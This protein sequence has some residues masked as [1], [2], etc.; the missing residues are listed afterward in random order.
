[1]CQRITHIYSCGHTSPD[2][3]L[4]K[5]GEA[6]TCRTENLCRREHHYVCAD[7]HARASKS[8]KAISG[9]S[10]LPDKEVG[11]VGDYGTNVGKHSV[12]VEGISGNHDG[13]LVGTHVV[14]GE[15]EL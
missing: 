8:S 14:L 12:E 7:C 3:V 4:C 2:F 9:G 15:M 10:E 13:T 5:D 1:M 11:G 6:G